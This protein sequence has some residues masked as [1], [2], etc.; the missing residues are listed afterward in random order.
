[1]NMEHDM[2]KKRTIKRGCR[3]SMLTANR[4]TVAYV[5]RKASGVNVKYV[6]VVALGVMACLVHVTSQMTVSM[7]EW[8]DIFAQITT[9]ISGVVNAHM[10]SVNEGA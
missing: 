10:R 8:G 9:T 3:L 1:M 7:K 6:D 4:K 5:I 2:S